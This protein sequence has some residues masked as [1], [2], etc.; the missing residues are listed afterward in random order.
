MINQEKKIGIIGDMHFKDLMA[1]SEYV[2]DQRIPEK[3]AVLDHIVDSFSDCQ[4]I[5]FMGDNM[6]SKNNSAESIKEFVEFVERFDSKEVYILLGN[7]EKRGNGKSAL[8]FM[9]EVNK[10]NWHIITTPNFSTDVLGKKVSFLP[11]MSKTELQVNTDHEGL[12]ILMNQLKGGDYL[13]AHHAISDTFSNLS[14]L[15]TNDF[16]EIVFPKTELENRYKLV[17]AGHIHF[18]TNY[19]KTIITGSVFTSEVG[20]HEKFVWKLN[21]KDNSVEQIKLPCRAIYKI[22]NP[23]SDTFEDMDKSS[24]VKCI[25]TEKGYKIDNVRE[26]LKK[27]D[28]YL[29]LEQ[30]P[31]ERKKIHFDEGAIDFTIEGLLQVYAKEKKLDINNLMIGYDLIK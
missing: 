30:Y 16:K 31:N 8:D 20:E 12:E 26:D 29:L 14:K 21:T 11:Y 22:E 2:K 13:F 27:F 23:Y 6:N 9:K 3:K 5:V 4:V 25:I 15:L 10:P 18:P 17:F 7:H 1:Y 19:G 28:A 24:I